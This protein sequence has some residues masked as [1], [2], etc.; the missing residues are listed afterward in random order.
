LKSPGSVIAGRRAARRTVAAARR[1]GGAAAL[2]VVAWA[3]P[4]FA[5]E[6]PLRVAPLTVKLTAASPGLPSDPSRLRTFP[7]GLPSP[8]TLNPLADHAIAARPGN[9]IAVSRTAHLNI[10]DYTGIDPG[11]GDNTFGNYVNALVGADRFYSTG[12]LD[13]DPAN[14]V[15]IFGQDTYVA[16]IDAGHPWAGPD[17]HSTLTGVVVNDP[18]L[19]YSP[20]DAM[21]NSLVITEPQAH[22]TSIAMVIAGAG[23]EL[24]TTG[25]TSTV[26][27]GIAPFTHLASGAIATA[28]AD[29]GTGAF[30]MTANTFLSTFK[31]FAEATFDRKINYP[32]GAGFSVEA[33][34]SGPTDVINA[35]FGFDDPAG[36]SPETVAADA[37]ARAHPRTTFVVSAGNS[38]PDTN[39]IGGPA[40]GY[41]VITVGAVGDTTSIN[42]VNQVADF[43]SRGPQD[44]AGNPATNTIVPAARARVDL[45]APGVFIVMATY[46]GVNSGKDDAVAASGTSFSA[47]VVSAGVAL[48]DSLSYH[49]TENILYD[50]PGQNWEN[51][52]DARLIKA[53]LM[54]SADKLP[55]WD[56]GQHVVNGVTRT[57]QALDTAQG[58][59]RINLSRAM[60]Q[61][62]GGTVDPFGVAGL[63]TKTGWSL[64]S[65]RLGQNVD[66]VIDSSLTAG[67]TLDATLAWFRDR[68]LPGVD[69]ATGDW[70]PATSTL[71]GTDLGMA[72]LYLEIW[73]ATFTELLAISETDYNTVQH[74]H[75]VLPGDGAYGI[76]VDYASQLFGAPSP[77]GET[78]GLAWMTSDVPEPSGVWVVVVA[79]GVLGRRRWGG[80]GFGG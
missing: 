24:H 42:G 62:V 25:T 9:P 47:P 36:V 35:S 50:A 67:D 34:V 60:D 20:T 52:R 21:G 18:K 72:T 33:T 29:D 63:V 1:L 78:F 76:R 17:G 23:E 14:V 19:R 55:G 44:F 79:V 30:S 8:L 59:G 28:V 38:G 66:Y 6:P 16:H 53:V 64:A 32:V 4:A 61:Y 80:G 11:T 10:Y 15:G 71:T 75:F 49:L 56:N 65:V 13:T 54:N 2:A 3:G 40:S 7:A 48:I 45:V 26:R 41:N 58:A 46:N 77:D 22:P 69:G 51:S 31:H 5:G 70:D 37:L 27:V 68:S 57:R 43:S 74:L 73:N 12:V 39:T